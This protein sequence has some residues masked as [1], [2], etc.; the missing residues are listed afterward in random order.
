[1]TGVTNIKERHHIFT[2]LAHFF[3]LYNRDIENSILGSG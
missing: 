3:L 1:M 2:L